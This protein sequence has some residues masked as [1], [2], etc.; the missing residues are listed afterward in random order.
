M[1]SCN[2]DEKRSREHSPN[3]YS[4]IKIQIT[5]VLNGISRSI[6]V[7]CE[8]KSAWRR[9]RNREVPADFTILTSA[10]CRKYTIANLKGK[11]SIR[12]GFKRI[13]RTIGQPASQRFCLIVIWNE[14]WRE[15][16]AA[17]TRWISTFI[18]D[19]KLL[20]MSRIASEQKSTQVPCLVWIMYLIGD[21]GSI[22]KCRL[23]IRIQYKYSI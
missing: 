19:S 15:R 21:R 9:A 13:T 7:K 16:R 3:T 5:P 23:D 8:H 10:A 2:F 12:H 1:I 17:L 4:L 11:S 22:I 6:D 20:L 14:L 18:Y